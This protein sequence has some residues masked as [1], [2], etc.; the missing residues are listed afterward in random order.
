MTRPQITEQV[1]VE[2][3][4]VTQV[5][6]RLERGRLIWHCRNEKDG[7]ISRVRDLPFRSL[8]TACGVNGRQ[9][10]V[11]LALEEQRLLRPFLLQMQEKLG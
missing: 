7:P 8:S 6:E 3:A 4:T 1:C 11:G 2:Y 10:F 5:Q 9:A